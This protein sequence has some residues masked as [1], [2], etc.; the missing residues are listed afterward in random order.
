MLSF[1]NS[2]GG[3]I[4]VGVRKDGIII[5]INDPDDTIL[6]ITNSLKYTLVPNVMPF[7]KI[8]SLTIE[9]KIIIEIQISTGTNRPYYLKKGSK[10]S[11]VYIRKGTSTQPMSEEAIKEM[12]IQS[13]GRSFEDCKSIEQDLTF[14][15][16]TDKMKNHNLPLKKALMITLKMIG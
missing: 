6:K 9:D 10:P 12:I 14:K 3:T 16:L 1:I 8:N 5:E 15:I 13:N 11:G 4:Y 2:Y 7:V